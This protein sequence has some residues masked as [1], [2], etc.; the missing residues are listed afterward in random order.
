M[1]VKDHNRL[2]ALAFCRAD[3]LFELNG[4]WD[5]E[6]AAGATQAVLGHEPDGLIGSSFMDLISNR[7]R[8][9]T[10]QLLTIASDKGRVDD[11]IVSLKGINEQA[12][13][14]AFSGYRVP[15]FNNH[16][17]LAL[18][19]EPAHTVYTAE[20]DLVCDEETGLLDEKSFSGTA[21]ERAQALQRAGGIARLSMIRIDN[22]E[23][24]MDRLGTSEKNDLMAAIGGILNSNSLGGNT[25][26][27]IDAENFSIVH[28]NKVSMDDVSD[29][30]EKKARLL[31]GDGNG[32]A[33][34]S[35]TLDADGAGM[36]QDQTAKAVI[37]IMRKFCDNKGIIRNESLADVL[38]TMM[39]KTTENVA[40]L[41]KIA[42]NGDF[43]LAFMPICELRKGTVKHFEAL[44][45]FNRTKLNESPYPL[46]EL[47]EETGVIAE[48]DLAVC[49]KAILLIKQ[50][51]LKET[52]PAVAINISG[53]SIAQPDFIQELYNIVRKE[54]DL[55]E[56]LMFEITES[57]AI[58]DVEAVNAATRKIRQLGFKFCLDDFGAGASS[59]NYLS[60]LDVDVVKFDGP[61]VRRACTTDKGHDVLQGMVKMCDEMN[62]WTVAERVETQKDANHLFYLGVSYGQGYLFGEAS[63]DPFDFA[64][65]FPDRLIRHSS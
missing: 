1:S 52:F 64:D 2:A 14:V 30:I 57:S 45:R 63:L 61:I 8:S 12:P 13:I 48:L 15:D 40:Y 28:S 56:K 36:N 60:E 43:D 22:L 51:S 50:F 11:V 19:V 7:D 9:L 44:I 58:E 38:S 47:A 10:E 49:H 34:R 46:I 29:A 23:G 6:F 33:V 31:T 32:V 65:K 26:S 3:L 17:F 53:A 18:K 5:I 35:S 16:F 4:H 54:E 37:Y 25:A 59:F 62:I 24:V 21:A 41:K 20:K 27:R 39:T 42:K 55:S